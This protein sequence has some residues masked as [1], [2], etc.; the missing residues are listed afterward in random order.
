MSFEFF[1]M[2]VRVD[3]GF[4]ELDFAEL[5]AEARAVD[6]E[7]PAATGLLIGMVQKMVVDDDFERF[8]KIA[9]R[10]RQGVSDLMEIVFAVVE[11]IAERPTEQ[12]SASP[13][14][15]PSD[16]PSSTGDS[17]SQVIS[18]LEQQHRPDLAL[19][20]LQAQEAR[21]AV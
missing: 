12:P 7:G 19:V 2:Q 14:G 1:E 8:W 9:R 11:A 18:R 3:P 10:E 13:A 20:V 17:S 4:G 5:M 15:L 21:A 16:A 6:S